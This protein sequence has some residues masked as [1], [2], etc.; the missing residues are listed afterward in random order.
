MSYLQ[1]HGG[2]LYY[3]I[4]GE[5]PPVV[6][7]HAGFLDS[8][9][10]NDQFQLFAKSAKVIRYD[11]RGYGRSSRP[12]E[13]YSDAEDLLALLK[14]LKIDRANILG[15]SN[16]GRIA[17]DFVSV[18]PAMVNS[19][20]LVSPGIHGYKAG[21]VEEKEWAE[22]DRILTRPQELAISEN[23][24]DDAVKMDL[25]FWASAQEGKSKSRIREIAVANSHIHKN[26]PYKL[27]K[28]PEPPAFTGL[29][30]IRIPTILITGDR[31]GKLEQTMTKKL[32]ELIPGSKLSLIKGADHIANMSRPEEFNAIVSS[33]LQNVDQV[34]FAASHV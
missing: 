19:L 25:D 26:P 11:A 32:H 23:R 9:M 4:A 8:R 34:S 7:I 13:E 12:N 18:H 5:G 15:I 20:I 24:I 27:Q 29:N 22:E 14:H 16:G 6:L 21:P 28:S 1:V 2:K 33:F 30:Q 17:F 31:D 10:W 3:E